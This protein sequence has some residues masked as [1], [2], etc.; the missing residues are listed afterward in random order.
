MFEILTIKYLGRQPRA[1]ITGKTLDRIIRRDYFDHYE[2]VKQKLSLIK[3][4]NLRGR[5]R[6]A[7]AVLKNSKGDLTKIDSY[8]ELCNDDFRDVVSQAEYPRSLKFG[9]HEI[10]GRKLKKIYLD[11]WNEYLGWLNKR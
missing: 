2:E 3:T 10:D 8:I 11:D 4:N 1:R 6:L 9:F 7:A 5:N